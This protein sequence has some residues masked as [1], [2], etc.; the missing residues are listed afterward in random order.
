[1]YIPSLFGVGITA[2]FFYHSLLSRTSLD[3]TYERIA[4][5][6]SMFGM[7]NER[8]KAAVQ[9]TI[10]ELSAAEEKRTQL[11]SKQYVVW[12]VGIVC[13]STGLV[14]MINSIGRLTHKMNGTRVAVLLFCIFL[15]YGSAVFVY[16]LLS[17]L[18]GGRKGFIKL[19]HGHYERLMRDEGESSFARCPKCRAFLIPD[20]I[21]CQTCGHRVR[22]DAE[23]DE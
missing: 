1:M 19:V 9:A 22:K 4:L 10:D 17:R 5:R 7:V 12:V 15:I 3:N 21:Y 18:R 14:G 6:N 13:A 16:V 20:S 8:D 11:F 2:S 23:P